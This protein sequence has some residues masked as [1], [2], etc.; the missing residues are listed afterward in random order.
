MEDSKFVTLI[1]KKTGQTKVLCA[2]SRSEGVV[3]VDDFCRNRFEKN[4]TLIV[5]RLV[6][7]VLRSGNSMY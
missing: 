2:I 1:Y 5:A 6:L 7:L 4:S 3:C